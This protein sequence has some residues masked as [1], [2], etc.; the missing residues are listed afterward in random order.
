MEMKS[1]K[2]VTLAVV[3]FL[4]M[5]VA[6]AHAGKRHDHQHNHNHGHHHGHHYHSG[7]YYYP[8]P[9]YGGERVIVGGAIGFGVVI[10]ETGYNPCWPVNT[11]ACIPPPQEIVIIQQQPPQD[12]SGF[13]A[14][15]PAPNQIPIQ[16]DMELLQKNKNVIRMTGKPT[17]PDL[18]EGGSA[19]VCN[20]QSAAYKRTDGTKYIHQQQCWL[21][22]HPIG[23]EPDDKEIQ[24]D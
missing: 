3:I 23:K 9:Y 7:V 6:S 13:R 22:F 5:I 15:R 8:P 1:I 18:P 4:S 19:I 17:A 20:A 12:S 14:V 21:H 2:M 24:G 11:S 10:G 16:L